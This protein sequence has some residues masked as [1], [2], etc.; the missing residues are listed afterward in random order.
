MYRRDTLLLAAWVL[1]KHHSTIVDLERKLWEYGGVYA[2]VLGLMPLGKTTIGE[3]KD[4][5]SPSA[6]I[7][8]GSFTCFSI[9]RRIARKELIAAGWER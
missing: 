8:L 9:E 2:R 5:T 3:R 4:E 1:K 7:G 6:T